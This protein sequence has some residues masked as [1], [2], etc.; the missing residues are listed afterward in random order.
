MKKVRI[1]YSVRSYYGNLLYKTR[2]IKYKLPTDNYG[3]I[4][5]GD[6]SKMVNED[7]H[8]IDKDATVLYWQIIDIHLPIESEV[9]A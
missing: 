1:R 3:F 5:F 8:K 7:I 4:L 2:T 6:L 9:G